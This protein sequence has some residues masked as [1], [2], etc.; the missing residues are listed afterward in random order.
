MKMFS[1]IPPLHEFVFSRNTRSRLGLSMLQF[2]TNTFLH[3]PVISLPTTTPPWP[4]AIVHPR[5]IIFSLGRFHN[6]PS[7]L[8]P[9]FIAIQSSPVWKKQSS[10]STLLQDSGSHPSPLG[11][12]LAICTRL[13]VLFWLNNVWRTQKGERSRVTPSIRIPSHWLKLIS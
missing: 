10:M 4:S 13:T 6:L 11:P 3:P 7:A 2:S 8:R 5:I 12:S 1:M 9:L